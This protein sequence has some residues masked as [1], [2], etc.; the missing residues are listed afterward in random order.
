MASLHLQREQPVFQLMV[1]LRKAFS[2]IVAGNVK[3]F[4][5][6]AVAQHGPYKMQGD[7][8]VIES[9]SHLLQTFVAQGR[10]KIDAASY[11]PCFELA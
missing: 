2:G 5:V 7:P 8:V 3:E 10:M 9:L 6:R 4:G 11:T 1:E